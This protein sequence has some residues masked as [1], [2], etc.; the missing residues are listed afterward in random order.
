MKRTLPQKLG[1]IIGNRDFFPDALIAEARNE[2][3]DVFNK[4]QISPVWLEA[5]ANKGGG[6]ETLEDAFK[7]ADLFKKNREEIMGIL[8]VLPNFGD[9]K[10]ILETIKQSSLNVPILIQGYPDDLN[11]LDVARRRDAYC[12]KLSVCNNLNQAGIPY[13]LTSQ[14]VSSPSSESFISDLKKFTAVCRVVHTLRGARIGALGARPGAFNTVRYSEKI[15]E[16]NGISISTMDLSEMIKFVESTGDDDT[17]VKAKL[18]E[19]EGY[20]PAPN[21]Q[22]AKLYQ[23]AKMGVFLDRFQDDYKLDATA[24]QCWTSLQLNLG[25]NVCTNMSMMSEALFPSA[26]EVDVMGAISMLALQAASGTPAALVDW[27]NNFA[28]DPDKCVLFHC[29]NWAKSFIP[30]GKIA[31]APILGTSVG[32]E[33]TVGALDGATPASRGLTVARISTDDSLGLIKSYVAEGEITN[34]DLKTFGNRAVAKIPNLNGLMNYVCR[35]G[36]E[37]HVGITLADVASILEEAL[38]RYLKWDVYSHNSK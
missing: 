5:E 10:G 18:S 38:G 33:N 29:G 15:L 36:F 25:C 24:I 17:M 16:R 37:H 26:C 27:N 31:N 35:N 19:V 13:S 6:V 28:D 20:L 8:V 4:L 34:D 22:K 23:I 1:V 3:L 2:M 12:G 21:I 9:E 30:N 32:V 11:R 7:C 14:H